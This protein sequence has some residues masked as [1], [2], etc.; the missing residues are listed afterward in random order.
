MFKKSITASIFVL[1]SGQVFAAPGSVSGKVTSL[2]A[3]GTSPAI[4]VTGNATPDNCDGGIYG[5]MGFQGTPEE[6]ARVYA[7]ALAMAVSGHSVAV[8]TNTDGGPCK[9]ENIQVTGG[10]N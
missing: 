8:Y 1:M 2:L 6:Q 4:R 7:T 5:W 3:S 10:L 9:I